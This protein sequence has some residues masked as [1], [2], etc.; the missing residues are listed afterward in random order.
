MTCKDVKHLLLS[1][2]DDE[3][4]LE[5]RKAIEAHLSVCPSCEDELEALAS[6]QQQLRQAYKAILTR[7]SPSSYVWATIREQLVREEHRKVSI[8]DLVKSRMK[9]QVEILKLRQPAWKVALA[10]VLALALILTL[11][12]AIPSLLSQSFEAKAKDIVM[13]NATVQALVAEAGFP[14][15]GLTAEVAIPEVTGWMRPEGYDRPV[16]QVQLVNKK[17]G[18]VVA[19]VIVEEETEDVIWVNVPSS[20]KVVSILPQ[21]PSAEGWGETAVEIAKGDAEVQQMLDSGAEIGEVIVLL[22]S[23]EEEDE[24]R[25][26]WVE[27]LQGE[28]SWFVEVDLT[29]REVVRIFEW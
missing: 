20:K 27:L 25:F 26:A 10:S 4:S 12:L 2:L 11:W 5:E 14:I 24:H 18:M 19:Y 22:P 13:K 9:G 8:L 1:Y 28:K 7:A 15:T 16:T 3:V 23:E 17:D 21:P 29:E 6:T